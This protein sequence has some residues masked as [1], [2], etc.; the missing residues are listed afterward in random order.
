MST[1]TAT[2]TALLRELADNCV[3]IV[4]KVDGGGLSMLTTDGRRITSVAT[5]QTGEQLNVLHDRYRD[6][7]CTEAWRHAAVV[8]TVSSTAGRWP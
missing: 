8:G 3:R 5:D 6:N 4:P 1:R 7:P 2:L